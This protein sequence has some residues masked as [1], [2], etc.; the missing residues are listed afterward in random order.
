MKPRIYKRR[1]LW[2]CRVIGE[3]WYGLG[4]TAGQAYADWLDGRPA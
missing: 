1:G 2:R 3:N 4:Y